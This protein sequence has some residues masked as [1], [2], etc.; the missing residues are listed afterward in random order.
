MEKGLSYKVTA[1]CAAVVATFS[2][3][4]EK[5]SNYYLY[6]FPE[7]RDSINAGVTNNLFILL[8]HRILV[9]FCPS[10]SLRHL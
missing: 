4:L 7:F 2:K 9:E 3:L 8:Q 6:Y 10:N 5:S 1:S